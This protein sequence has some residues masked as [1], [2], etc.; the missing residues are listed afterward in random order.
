M[1]ISSVIW[2]PSNSD[3]IYVGTDSGIFASEDK[4]QT[5]SVTPLYNA[6]RGGEG[7]IYTE[8]RQLFWQPG[9]NR[10]CAATHGRGIWRSNEIK[11][12]I[13]V[14]KDQICVPIVSICDGSFSRPYNTFQEALEAAG[15][16]S[17]IIFKSSGNHEEIPASAAAVIV[18]KRIT[19]T[20]DNNGSGAPAPVVIK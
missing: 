12:K 5:W 19:I 4:G 13:Y 10:L 2:H 16:G 14:D 18:D 7:P 8:V 1:H 3:W 15:H 11:D 6:G 9:R 17:E 20:L